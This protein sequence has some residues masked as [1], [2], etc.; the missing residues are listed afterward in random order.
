MVRL[1]GHLPVDGLSRGDAGQLLAFWAS[2]SSARSCPSSLE[3][4][5]SCGSGRHHR[6]RNPA[7]DC[8]SRAR[9]RFQIMGGIDR[10]R[11]FQAYAKRCRG[12]CGGDGSIVVITD[13]DGLVG[14]T[15][16][17]FLK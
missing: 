10:D 16:A 14:Y 3:I 9:V 12:D 15:E 5:A 7:L 17:R 11:T 6:P 1:P 13:L 4:R 2:H 8:W